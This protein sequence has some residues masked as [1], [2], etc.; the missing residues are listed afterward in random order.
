MVMTVSVVFFICWIPALTSLC[1]LSFHS[2]SQKQGYALH[3]VSTILV[4]FNCTANPF[5]YVLVSHRFRRHFKELVCCL[6]ASS[7]AKVYPTTQGKDSGSVQP[8]QIRL[9]SLADC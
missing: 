9:V 7:K 8:V 5:I 6:G 4:L 2:V 1:V 3:V